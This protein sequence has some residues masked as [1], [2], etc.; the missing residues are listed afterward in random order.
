VATWKQT[1]KGVPVSEQNTEQQVQVRQVTD[2]QASWTEH[3][4]GE[5]GSF[6]IQLILDD[7]A[8]EYILLPE[9]DDAKVMLKLFRST[10][11]VYFDLGNKVLIPSNVF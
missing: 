6:T 5:P 1:R 4:R 10:D 2:V 8:E 11:A 3:E 9:A 7:G